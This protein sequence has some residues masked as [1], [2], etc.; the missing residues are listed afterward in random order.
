MLLWTPLLKTALLL[1]QHREE[2]RC[3]SWHGRLPS[4]PSQHSTRW[5]G[6]GTGP[7][8]LG[9]HKKCPSQLS[10]GSAA[11][12]HFQFLLLL[13]TMRLLQTQTVPCS[14]VEPPT[15]GC[16]PAGVKPTSFPYYLISPRHQHVLEFL[17]SQPND[18]SLGFPAG[19]WLGTA[20]AEHPACSP[21]ARPLPTE[22]SPAVLCTAWKQAG[23]NPREITREQLIRIGHGTRRGN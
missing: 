9:G 8:V 23:D 1:Q 6:A 19:A 13:I 14:P 4:G 5:H 17:R 11:D 20:G 22:S 2:L 21:R 18:L 10:A 16:A 15:A 7:R 12:S 3:G